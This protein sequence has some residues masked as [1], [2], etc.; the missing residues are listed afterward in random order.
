M[1]YVLKL[2]T[3][4]LFYF[5]LIAFSQD[6]PKVDLGGA[7]RFNYN[8]SSWKPQ[9]KKRGGDFGFD[10]F[11][12]NA[13][14][15]YKDV[16]LDAEY[17]LY[18]KGFGGGMLKQGIIGYNPNSDNQ[19]QMGLV[20]APFGI[21][22]YNS[23][24]WFFNINYYVGLEDDYDMG[25]KYQHQAD[26]WHVALAY[27]KNAEE[28]NFGNNSDLSPDRYSY[29]VSSINIDG[30]N[31]LRNKEVNQVNGKFNYLIKN[32]NLKHDFGLSGEYGGLYNLDTE[33]M[34]NHSAAAIHYELTGKKFNL[35]AQASYYQF[36]PKEPTGQPDNVIAMGAYGAEYLV[37]AEASTYTL[38]LSYDIPVKLGPISNIQLY[39]DFGYI[40]KTEEDFEN[41]M[42]NVTGALVSAGNVYTYIDYAAGKDQPWLGPNWTNGLA[43][44]DPNAQWESRFNINVGYYF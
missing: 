42:M 33:E 18:S 20:Q 2:G 25:L 1:H 23:H 19:F 12:V 43:Q 15:S 24:N 30:E 35:K 40:N 10:V 13:K 37:A 22:E 28:L 34:G 38:G 4:L 39:N 9:Q 8:L 36:N 31:V 44:G 14:A 3:F 17:R 16:Y 29:D 27:F 11:R 5:P 41:S 6:K 21:T 32:N 26:N 7:L